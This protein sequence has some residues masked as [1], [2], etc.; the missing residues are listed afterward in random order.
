MSDADHPE[1]R[2]ESLTRRFVRR[3]LRADFRGGE[4]PVP[5]PAEGLAV[6]TTVNGHLRSS[7]FERFAMRWFWG[8]MLAVCTVALAFVILA[9]TISPPDE[10]VTALA[11]TGFGLLLLVFVVRLQAGVRC[12]FRLRHRG[13]R[14]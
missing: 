8:G 9:V 4:C 1:G 7:R 12:L 13:R 5:F 3:Y 10:A 2:G 11:L 6:R 14:S